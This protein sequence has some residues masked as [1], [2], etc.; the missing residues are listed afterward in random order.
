[1]AKILLDVSEENLGTLL[2]V[3]NNLKEGLVNR[4]EVNPL[5]EKGAMSSTEK[6][7]TQV[8]KREPR[9]QP[10]ANKVVYEEEQMGLVSRGKYLDPKS[11]KEKLRG[12][13]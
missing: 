4:V 1:M 5:L 2:L 7:D 9:Y 3:L 12:R 11:F 6:G 10:K 13:K 8:R